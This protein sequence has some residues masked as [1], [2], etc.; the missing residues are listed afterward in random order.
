MKEKQ[1][2]DTVDITLP[3]LGESITKAVVLEWHVKPGDWVSEGDILLEVGTDKVNSEI[4]STVNGIVK[5]LLFEPDD[6]VPVGEALLR[7]ERSDKVPP[8][9]KEQKKTAKDKPAP[10]KA[11]KEAA[12]PKYPEV[13]TVAGG[14]AYTLPGRN[15]TSFYSPLVKE[16]AIQHHI[17][18]EELARIPGT[19]KEGRVRKSDIFNYLEEGRPAQFVQTIAIPEPAGFKVPDLKFDKGTGEIHELDRMGKMIA[20]HMVFSKIVSPHVTAY[21]E[22]DMSNMVNWRNK[23]KDAFF[24][25][26]GEKLTYTPLFIRVVADAIK[27]FPRI[28]SSRDGDKIIIKKEINIG[29]GAALPDGNIIVPVVKD[30]GEKDLKTLAFDVNRLVESARTG[31]LKADDTSGGTFTLSNVGTFGSLMGTPV[32]NQPQAAILATGVIKKKAVVIETP[33]GDKIEPRP[34][35]FLCLS[36]DHSFIDGHLA[37]SFLKRI[38]DNFEQFNPKD[39]L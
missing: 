6:E 20:D 33:E 3:K 18:Y 32:I 30:A 8:K 22:T 36:F 25:K 9:K 26:H 28:N 34:M 2:G 10:K 24:K 4:P 29:I 31:K 37:G 19:G 16:I 1:T 21:V 13:K 35:M 12:K 7:I 27:A 39:K 23:H 11:P 14:Q 17:S 15:D 5:E 38:S